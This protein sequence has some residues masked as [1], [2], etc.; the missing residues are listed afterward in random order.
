MVDTFDFEARLQARLRARAALA[1]RPFDAV[2]IAHQAVATGTRRR[3]IGRLDWPSR[4]RGY[5]VVIVVLLLALALLGAA[6]LAGALQRKPPPVPTSGVSNG[7]VAFADDQGVRAGEGPSAIY[8]VKDGVAERPVIGSP[9]DGSRQVCPSFSPDGTRLAYSEA[10]INVTEASLYDVAVVIVTVNAAGMPVGPELRLATSST[11]VR[12]ACPEWAPDGQSV[13][14]LTNA[15]GQPPELWIGHLDGTETRVAGWDAIPGGAEFDWSPDGTA[16]VAVG[17]D[18][19]SL[20]IVPVDGGAP[21]LL[22]RAAPGVHFS[23]AQWSP[24]GTRIAAESFTETSTESGTSTVGSIEIYRADGSGSPIELAGGDVGDSSWSPDGREIAY[25]RNQ[26]DPPAIVAVTLDTGEERVIVSHELLVGGI[27]WAPDGTR[28]VLVYD[29]AAV[30]FV[31]VVGD[32]API[33]LT[34]STV[35]LEGIDESNVSWQAVFP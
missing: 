30:G 16:V 19:S 18:D 3:W 11:D 20:W 8:L 31:S 4:P 14:F 7:W 33:V 26:S 6:T 21:R 27:T 17:N 2:A 32:P 24:D 22:T 23:A 35:D 34:H 12:D 1:S 13:A 5:A 25:F 29:P 10:R 15:T 28:L 9:G